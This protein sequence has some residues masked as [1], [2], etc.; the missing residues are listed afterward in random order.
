MGEEGEEEF[1]AGEAGEDEGEGRE[2]GRGRVGEEAEEGEG[3]RG[4]G[5]SGK[6]E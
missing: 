1:R 4:V 5:R 2:E 3:E 6:A